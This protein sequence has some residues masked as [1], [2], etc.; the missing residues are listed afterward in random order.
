MQSDYV[1]A[2]QTVNEGKALGNSPFR[3]LSHD[4]NRRSRS[5]LVLALVKYVISELNLF[6][7][8][9]WSCRTGL[10]SK[11]VQRPLEI[12]II[13]AMVHLLFSLT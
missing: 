4:V 11:T 9:Y 3:F 5:H 10:S 7:K 6:L 12:K 1:E 13:G 2:I 8:R